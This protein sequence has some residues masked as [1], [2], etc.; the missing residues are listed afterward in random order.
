[1][2]DLEV[3]IEQMSISELVATVQRVVDWYEEQDIETSYVSMMQDVA[4]QYKL[5]GSMSPRQVASMKSFL[6]HNRK[7]W[8]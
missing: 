5:G 4:S 1:M 7:A 3:Q 6:R 8:Y 2:N